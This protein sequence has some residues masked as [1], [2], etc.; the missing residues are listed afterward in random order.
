MMV[1]MRAQFLSCSKPTALMIP[2]TAGRAYIK[3]ITTLNTLKNMGG[4]FAS[5]EA[6]MGIAIID[7]AISTAI[8]SNSAEPTS[9][10]TAI[11]VIPADRFFSGTRSSLTS[12]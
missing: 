5:F 7:I 9:A 10:K 12:K 11:T 1:E 8:A 3:G 2:Q 6:G 4:I